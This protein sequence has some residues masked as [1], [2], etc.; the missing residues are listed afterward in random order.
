MQNLAATTKNDLSASCAENIE[1]AM[2]TKKLT[3]SASYKQKSLSIPN[4]P[5]HS[6]K[7]T[8]SNI[9]QVFIFYNISNFCR[10]C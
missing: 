2:S 10:K 1:L 7:S 4:S 6:V 5:A 8:R 3:R 9:S